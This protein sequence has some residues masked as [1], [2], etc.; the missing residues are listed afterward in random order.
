MN[1]QKE[2]WIDAALNSLDGIQ[3][4]TPPADLYE[5]ILDRKNQSLP[6]R[7]LRVS[8]TPTQRWLVAASIALL[9]FVNVLTCLKM[10]QEFAAHQN[11]AGVFAIEY[12][13]FLKPVEI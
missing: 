12:F 2:N 11:P 13:G 5:R 3:R 4:A 10:K 9:L 8:M 6:K 7:A 1:T